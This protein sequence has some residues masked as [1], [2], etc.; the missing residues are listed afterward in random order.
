MFEEKN[1]KI[2]TLTDSVHLQKVLFENEELESKIDM[3][4]LFQLKS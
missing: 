1:S 3:T 2:M 4:L